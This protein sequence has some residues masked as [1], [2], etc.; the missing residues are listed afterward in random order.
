MNNERMFVK[1]WV[2]M[3]EASYIAKLVSQK[4]IDLKVKRSKEWAIKYI[5][6]KWFNKCRA[7]LKKKAPTLKERAHDTIRQAM[8]FQYQLAAKGSEAKARE[9][10]CDVIRDYK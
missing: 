5:V 2:G 1:G 3:I 6:R 8:T 7:F 9:I 10:V 4:Y